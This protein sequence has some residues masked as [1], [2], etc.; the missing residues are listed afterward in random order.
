MMNALI[1]NRE[2]NS[3]IERWI[4][5][6]HRDGEIDSYVLPNGILRMHRNYWEHDVLDVYL[7]EC[8]AIH[9]SQE[10]GQSD[11]PATWFSKEVTIQRLDGAWQILVSEEDIKK[12]T[13]SDISE[14]DQ[15]LRIVSVRKS[16]GIVEIEMIGRT[17]E[18]FSELKTYKDGWMALA[19]DVSGAI[20]DHYQKTHKNDIK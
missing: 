6:N 16:S 7:Q 17:Q 10:S 14:S 2:E 8:I 18:H 1:T 4:I 12:W 19:K 15:A 9:R 13:S 5:D 3:V 11:D 20:E